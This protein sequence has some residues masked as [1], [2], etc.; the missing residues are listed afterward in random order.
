M[1][2]VHYGN[3][4][5]IYDDSLQT[6]ESFQP[7]TY[8][9]RFHKMKGFH[10]ED[11]PDI[12]R[13]D[14]KV[15]GVHQEK[16]DKVL[17]TF[18]NFERNLGVILSG[19]KG[20][21]KSLFA[22]MLAEQA[23]AAGIPVIV[24]DRYDVG[25]ASYLETIE[26]E[27]MV[28]FDEFDKTFGGVKSDEDIDPQCSMLSL[29]D[30]MT[31]GKK[32]FVITC[33]DA[34]KLNEYLVNRPG[35][36]HYHFR[37]EYPSANEIREY[38]ADNIEMKYYAE[39]E[40]VVQFANRFE[41]NYDCLRAIAYEL[42]SG[43]SFAAAIADLN[44][45]NMN[46]YNRYNLEIRFDNGVSAFCKNETIDM[47]SDMTKWSWFADISGSHQWISLEYRPDSAEFDT[48]HMAYVIRPQSIVR[49]S[50]DDEDDD[51][52]KKLIESVKN[53]KVEG[54]IVRRVKRKDLH[55]AL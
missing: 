8:I 44:I 15:Y 55:F 25:I 6:F 7:K 51:E 50:F 14:E 53:A 39:I 19:D 46:S 52:N 29:F 43:L 37:F 38:L 10:L 18:G 16:V 48:D 2:V 26:Q 23:V 21:G 24:V 49:I 5:D 31:G 45:V 41:L 30:G 27:V 9:V 47:F 13:G 17:R 4:Y 20:I 12:R 34:N 22:K 36:F 11:Y 1:K 33:N 32:L 42:N 40:E 28:M 3:S 54:I 35:R